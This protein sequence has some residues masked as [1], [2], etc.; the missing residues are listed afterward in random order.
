MKDALQW[1][2]RYRRFWEQQMDS[3]ADFLKDPRNEEI[4]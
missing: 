3:L 2:D 4:E 1:L